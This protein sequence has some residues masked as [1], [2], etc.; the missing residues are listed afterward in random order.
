MGKSDKVLWKMKR[1]PR[2]WRIG[3]LETIAYRLD[4]KIYKGVGSHVIFR[5]DSSSK[6]LSVPAGRP[7]KPVYVRQFLNMVNE[8]IG[9]DDE[10]IQI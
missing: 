2:D 3:D 10:Q 6:A 8:I 7:V 1:N 5:H 4:I 9:Q